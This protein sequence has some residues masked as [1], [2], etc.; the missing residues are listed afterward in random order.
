M[1][2]SR[3]LRT[4]LLVLLLALPT[5]ARAE[6]DP[7]VTE[8]RAFFARGAELVASA[9]WAEALA[10]FEQSAAVRAHPITTYNIGAC[11]RA[12]GRYT[13]ARAHFEKALAESDTAKGLLP[14]SLA[15]DARA[16]VDQ[17]EGLVAHASVVIEPKEA[18][19]AVDGSP[20]EFRPSK[21]GSL[22]AIAGLLGPGAGQAAPQPRFE[23][24][25]DPGVH[26]ITLTREGFAAVVV[27]RTFA[28]KSHTELRLEL[29]RLPA[30]IHVAANQPGA[31]VKVGDADVGS[32]P[33]DVTRPAGSYRI[34]VAKGGFD[35]YETQIVVK[36]GEESNLLA[37]LS[38]H[39]TPVTQRWWFWTV[40][41]LLVTG[42]AVTTY[43]LTRTEPAAERPALDGG[44]LGWTIKLR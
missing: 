21:D 44:G 42:A 32:V 31:I 17:I 43:F 30:V 22:V 28:P 36:A 26:V 3:R 16:Y 14:P 7:K 5:L 40:A 11:E 25:L 37:P 19:I 2:S 23:L 24:V 38:V 29:D 9:Q 35:T 33:V 18:R 13:R 34:I 4:S 27:N 1:R 20:L 39:K 8:G 6:D 12:L 41:G 10:A 15:V